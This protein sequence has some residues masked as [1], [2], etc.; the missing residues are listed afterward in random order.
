MRIAT[1]RT[2]CAQ[3]SMP[4]LGVLRIELMASND[5]KNMYFILQLQPAGSSRN[6]CETTEGKSMTETIS[7]RKTNSRTK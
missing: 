5:A 2:C 1:M 7:F 4:K 6:I 3:L